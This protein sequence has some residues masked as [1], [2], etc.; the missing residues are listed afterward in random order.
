MSMS[1]FRICI[2]NL[3]SL[4]INFWS[5]NTW[6]FIFINWG[7]VCLLSKIMARPRSINSIIS[8]CSCRISCTERGH[9]PIFR[10]PR[11][12]PSDTP[13]LI[14]KVSR[15]LIFTR[16]YSVLLCSSMH[17]LSVPLPNQ[18]S[19]LFFISENIFVWWYWR[20]VMHPIPWNVLPIWLFAGWIFF[21]FDPL[22]IGYFCTFILSRS[23]QPLLFLQFFILEPINFG[24]ET[25]QGLDNRDT[26]F[27]KTVHLHTFCWLHCA[28]YLIKTNI[29]L[30]ST[31]TYVT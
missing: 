3:F 9:A 10:I 19:I 26:E 1:H 4:S 17:F 15:N 13:S 5:K 28:I 27:V 29:R 24:C 31:R 22:S 30:I 16:A 23:R 6:L 14:P 8:Y 20:R 21:T 25:S 12:L 7:K 11:R 18:F 2:P